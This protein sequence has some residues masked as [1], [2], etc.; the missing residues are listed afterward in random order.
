MW[1]C[2]DVL[3]DLRGRRCG[4]DGWPNEEQ[5]D[6]L[7]ERAAGLF[8]YAVATIKFVNKQNSNPRKRLDILLRSPE[9][10]V[11]EGKT[12]FKPNTTLHSLCVSILREA[13]G[14]DDPEDYPKIRSVLGAMTLAMSPLP[15]SAIATLLGFDT[16]D[17]FPLLTSVRSLL[18]VPDHHAE[19]LIGCLEL[20]NRR[21]EQNMCKLPDGVVNSEVDN[22]KERVE[23]YIEHGLRYSCKSWHKHLVSAA[24]VH[25]LKITSALHRFLEGKFLFWLEALS[26]PGAAREAVDALEATAKW[27]DLRRMS[28]LN[29]SQEFTRTRSRHHRLSLSSMTTF[30]L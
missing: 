27:L 1:G 12:N 3:S 25:A 6:L 20:M 19:L 23:Q 14:E 7:C 18:I 15:P 8:V 26:I 2:R 5:L 29:V 11:H 22:L 30:V 21:L 24:P 28:L 10:S 17:V 13:F 9:S 4:L 16:E